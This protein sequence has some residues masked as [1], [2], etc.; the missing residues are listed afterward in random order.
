MRRYSIASPA[1]ARSFDEAI[2]VIMRLELVQFATAHRAGD[3]A[4]DQLPQWLEFE[5]FRGGFQ[6]IAQTP[7]SGLFEGF[8]ILKRSRCG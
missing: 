1:S 4:S 8:S 7:F 6:M 3:V 5:D 2:A